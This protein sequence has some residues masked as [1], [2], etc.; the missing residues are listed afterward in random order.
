MATPKTKRDATVADA[1]RALS[2]VAAEL[3]KRTAQRPAAEAAV[4]AAR[5]KVA[6]ITE[7]RDGHLLGSRL[8]GDETAKRVVGEKTTEQRDA[9]QE[10]YDAQ[11]TLRQLRGALAVLEHQKA[12][13]AR[14]V[15]RAQ[16]AVDEQQRDA[17]LQQLDPQVAALKE[18]INAVLALSWRCEERSAE[19]LPEMRNSSYDFT[20]GL[21]R[22]LAAHL[23]DTSTLPRHFAKHFR[24]LN[25][26]DHRGDFGP[27]VMPDDAEPTDDAAVERRPALQ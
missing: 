2:V 6:T 16:N 19:L 25:A 3:D 26:R 11:T 23:G 15:V 14:A 5:A 12:T 22:P 1:E 13:A 18:T 8:D 20:V 24:T 10:L 7:E 17:K 21:A 4:E 27:G 9:E